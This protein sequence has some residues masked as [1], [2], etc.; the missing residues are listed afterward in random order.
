MLIIQTWWISKSL[1]VCNYETFELTEISFIF[2]YNTKS[3]IYQ[4]ANGET[5]DWEPLCYY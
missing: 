5:Y 2:D 1:T 4:I 3:I